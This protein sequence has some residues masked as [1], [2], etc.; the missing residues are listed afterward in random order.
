[1]PGDV[2]QRRALRAAVRERPGGLAFE[3]EQRV[4]AAGPEQLPEV[5]VLVAARLR[6]LERQRAASAIEPREERGLAREQRSGARGRVRR[7]RRQRAR[8]GAANARRARSRALSAD[9]EHVL[10][11][12]RLGLERG[13]GAAREREV[14]GGGLLAERPRRREVVADEAHHAAAAS[15]ARA[16]SSSVPCGRS[17]SRLRRAAAGDPR[18]VLPAVSSLRAPSRPRASG[19]SAC[20]TARAWLSPSRRYSMDPSTAGTS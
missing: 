4:S 17:A 16:T 13:V 11:R 19:T 2:G 9:G 10:V 20:S 6:R 5:V 3:V 15:G 12:Q 18:E 14:Q 7:E 1:M 8:R